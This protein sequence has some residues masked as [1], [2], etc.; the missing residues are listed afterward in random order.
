MERDN[1]E[2]N[3][4]LLAKESNPEE[5]ERLLDLLRNI[6][7]PGQIDLIRNQIRQIAHER[8]IILDHI[9]LGDDGITIANEG[10]RPETWTYQS[11]LQSIGLMV[12][13][14]LL[15]YV[16]YRNIDVIRDLV[17]DLG[18]RAIDIVPHDWMIR[19]VTHIVQTDPEAAR[20]LFLRLL[21][22]GLLTTGHD[23]PLP[24]P[25]SA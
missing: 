4:L 17:F 8:H 24:P 9:F 25:A 11:V 7:D 13:I 14:T 21:H 20:I 15:G 18:N 23:L 5:F 10:R 3:V 6:N 16:I 1:N 19:S 12:A 2:I 22:L